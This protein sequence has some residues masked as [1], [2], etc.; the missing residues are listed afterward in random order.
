MQIFA[1]IRRI[2]KAM[3]YGKP[4]KIRGIEGVRRLDDQPK[5]NSMTEFL[6]QMKSFINK[7]PSSSSSKGQRIIGRNSKNNRRSKDSNNQYIDRRKN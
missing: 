3:D 6:D 1:L 2:A 7:R 5:P 4:S